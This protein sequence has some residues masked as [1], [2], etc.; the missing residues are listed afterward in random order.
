M[1]RTFLSTF[2]RWTCAAWNAFGACTAPD[3]DAVRAIGPAS[4]LNERTV[5]RAR[6]A[7]RITRVRMACSLSVGRRGCEAV[8]QAA[9]A[10]DRR[11]Q[12]ERAERHPDAGLVRG[13][14]RLAGAPLQLGHRLDRAPR[15]ARAEEGVGL[16]AAHAR[17]EL[18]DLLGIVIV[19]ALVAGGGRARLALDVE[20]LEAGCL[21]IGA[22][23]LVVP[24]G[25]GRGDGDP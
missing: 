21:E 22:Q 8:Q 5:R 3:S 1:N 6:A 4:A 2:M 11:R 7:A 15:R 13:D 9:V 19:D 14:D 12:A 20:D 10:L 24:L 23:P 17:G 16:G 25:V 18:D